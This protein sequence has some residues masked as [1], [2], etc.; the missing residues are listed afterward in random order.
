MDDARLLRYSRQ[1]L[2]PEIDITGQ[3]K[4]LAA[5]VAIFGLGGLGS[6]IALYLA[7]AGVGRLVLVDFDT[8]ELS[9][10]QRQIIHL[11]RDLGRPKVES[12]REKLL[13]L[14]PEIQVEVE[15]RVLDGDALD[16]VVAGVD[17]V[18]DG[19]DNFPTR[20][21][22][23]A[24]CLRQRRPLVSGAA[25]RFEGQ[26]SVY[27]PGQGESPCY[28]CL[29]DDGAGTDETCAQTGVVAPLLGIIGSVQALEALKVLA[30]IGTP[31][32]GRLL[33]FDGLQM[34]W[35]SLRFKR[36]PRCPVCSTIPRD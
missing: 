26:V 16:A 18:L 25:I 7:A 24:A 12:A 3:R 15:T 21:G 13:A 8:V 20:F 6:P 29:Y 27:F 31:L 30:G 14:N 28:R 36:D 34:E 9:N 2:L 11:T 4:L 1:I 35:R 17:L 19:T 33:V 5:S 22:L 10:L 23:N 32:T